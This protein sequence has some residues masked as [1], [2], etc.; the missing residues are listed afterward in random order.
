[1]KHLAPE[2]SIMK[3]AVF[4]IIFFAAIHA[5]AQMPV[6]PA[7]TVEQTKTPVFADFNPDDQTHIIEHKEPLANFRL[8]LEYKLPNAA[9]KASVRLH[10]NRTLDLTGKNAAEWQ[11]LDLQYEQLRGKPASFSATVNGRSF[12]ENEIIGGM[13]SNIGD[14][15][16]LALDHDF[17]AMV[18]FT[19]RGDGAL[20]SKCNPAKWGADAKML[21]LSDG[22][23][24]YEV[25]KCG[26][27]VGNISGLNDGKSH[28]VVLRSRNGRVTL[29]VDGKLDGAKDNLTRPDVRQMAFF[30]AKGAKGN[31]GDLKDGDVENLRFWERALNDD[32]AK[33][34]SS[35]KSDAVN[36]PIV[37]WSAIPAIATFA[38]G[39]PGVPTKLALI[40]SGGAEI[41]NAWVQPLCDADHAKIISHWSEESLAEG[42]KIFNM[43]CITCH[44]SL[45]QEGSMPTSRHFQ[46]EP[47]KNG[48]DPFCQFQTL[49]QGYNLMMPMPMFT[50][51]QRYATLHYIRETFVAPHNKGELFKIDDAYLAS[52]PLG[53][54]TLEKQKAGEDP[55]R[56]FEKMNFGPVLEWTYQMAP[57]NI[58]YKGIAVRLD[59][60]DGGVSKGRTWMI[61]D[62]DTMRV[63]T[64]M[65][66]GF[67]DWK[68]VAFDGSHNSHASLTGERLFTNPV[69]PG[70]ANP[71]DGTWEDPRF[72][73]RDGKPYGPLPREWMNYRGPVSQ[74]PARRAELHHRRRRSARRPGGR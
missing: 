46:R 14:Q 48:N 36:T 40:T 24:F 26:I 66:G 4:T 34:T 52:L 22:K 63:A 69:G 42:G 47:F 57:N 74:W 59:P 37:N 3:F 23:V 21:S 1:M 30:I 62:H 51:E 44:G 72:R 71:R 55:S 12:V 10:E 54:R 58:A 65:T 38:K 17:T 8:Q 6:I 33:Q 15:D 60:G 41:R 7:T 16:K 64:A 67:I 28:V 68:G 25:G 20:F 19:S 70:W 50:P 32:E 13:G 5:H 18:R 31:V 27:L 2:H 61:Y 43:L 53:M 9:S 73:G 49:T 35:G 11:T 56:Q 45:T 39:I 29:F